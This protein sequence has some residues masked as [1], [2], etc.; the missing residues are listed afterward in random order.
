MDE[1]YNQVPFSFWHCRA[2]V[3]VKPIL[4][5]ADDVEE[6]TGDVKEQSCSSTPGY[7]G[8]QHAEWHDSCFQKCV[9]P[10]K[11]C[12]VIL[13]VSSEPAATIC[14]DHLVGDKNKGDNQNSLTEWQ[15]DRVSRFCIYLL[16]KIITE[17]GFSWDDTMVCFLSR[18]SFVFSFLCFHYYYSHCVSFL[19]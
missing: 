7:W 2:L 6:L 17:S 4:F 5:V 8:F 12:T 3:E 16:D 13:S 19:A 10:G 11:L 9:V 1:I 15:M 18:Y 14:H